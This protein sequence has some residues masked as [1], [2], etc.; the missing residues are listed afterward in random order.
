M[1]AAENFCFAFFKT[2]KFAIQFRDVKEVSFHVRRCFHSTNTREITHYV[3]VPAR[4]WN[5]QKT[6]IAQIRSYL[7]Y[8]WP[9][10]L[11]KVIFSV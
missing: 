5:C 2:R 1:P 11:A 9:F 10:Y 3:G 7:A 6:K 8:F 4:V